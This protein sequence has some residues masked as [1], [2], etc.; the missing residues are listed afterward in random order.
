MT[1]RAILL[2]EGNAE[3]EHSRLAGFLDFF[4]V[5][6]E[7]SETATFLDLHQ[8][9]QNSVVFGSVFAVSTVVAQARKSGRPSAQDSTFYAYA[10]ANR[11]ES[12]RA[13]Q[14]LTG[15]D[16]IFLREAP[17][18]T[19]SLSVSR[20]HPELTGPMGG[21]EISS[22][23]RG[24][25]SILV[26]GSSAELALTSFITA[27][28]APVFVRFQID[29]VPIFFS[30]S[31]YLLDIDQA[32]GS[33]YYDVKEHIC[34][35]VPL[36]MFILHMFRDIAWQPQELGACLIIDDP[37]LRK[38]YG[39]CD[40]RTLRGLMQ[41]YGFTTNI[42]FIPWNWRRT[43]RSAAKF[44]RQEQGPFSVSIHGCDH[45][46]AEFGATSPFVLNKRAKLAQSRMRSH[47]ARTGVRHDSVMVFPQG[48]FSSAS[49][50][51][52]KRNGYVA[53]VNT[54][55]VPVDSDGARTR[56]RDVWDVA[57]MRYADFPIFTR[58]YASHGLENFAFDLLLGKPCLIVTHHD[59]FSDNCER[60]IE[61]IKS[62]QSLPCT[63]SWRPLGE[64]IRRACRRRR[65]DSGI[66][67]IEMYGSELLIGNPLEKEVSVHVTKRE[68]GAEFV[69]DVRC[70]LESIS[71][72][73]D[74]D[75]LAC[76]TRVGPT[77]EKYFQ[78]FYREPSEDGQPGQSLRF[79]LS[80]A[81]RRVLS[82]FRDEYL[83]KGRFL[84]N[85]AAN[86]KQLLSQAN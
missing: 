15:N 36:V 32:V 54:E 19:L 52:L 33:G 14:S 72:T 38:S 4:G 18:G 41:R 40:F 48:V 63:L 26:G 68:N 55:L 45:I 77:E 20:D 27:K 39:S 24:E 67:E 46:A 1:K 65:G 8:D 22:Q 2:S 5:P 43:S 9:D 66:F 73:R 3:S 13:L 42:A 34:S 49:T 69:T 29:A 59:F 23:L 84:S 37:L 10:G 62:L 28:G 44:F 58:R 17:G 61:L 7:Y 85:T 12:E 21:L 25:D 50:E 47:E 16:D 76:E 70:D 35:V 86:I 56:I 80:V 31:S 64:V 53:A 81:L 57:I 60:L 71:W 78:I 6:W 30:A 51:A 74:A 83:S 82:E 75:H 11:K 79:E